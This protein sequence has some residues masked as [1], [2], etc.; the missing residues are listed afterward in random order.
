MRRL[1]PLWGPLSALTLSLAALAFGFD[2]TH[3][4]WMLQVYDIAQRQPVQALPF[5]DLVLAWNRGV[6]YGWF[7]S[8]GALGQVVLIAIAVVVSAWL[9]RWA[10]QARR[11]LTA[12]ALGLIIGGALAN[13]LDR[14]VHGA[15]ADFFL[16]HWGL[17]SWYI[18][19]IADVAVVAGV[20]LLVY[21]SF[22]DK[23]PRSAKRP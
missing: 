1:G 7:S 13:G 9:W 18:F 5:L 4:W 6:S 20:V 8:H 23:E 19:N 10:A 3:K 11:P 12:S 2:Q 22:K 17:W 14:A 15:V 21:D 16:L